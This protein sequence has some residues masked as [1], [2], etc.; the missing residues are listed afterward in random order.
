VAKPRQ[1]GEDTRQL[2]GTAPTDPLHDDASGLL[3]TTGKKLASWGDE[4]GEASEDDLENIAERTLITGAPGMSGF[5]MDVGGDGDGPV[6][7]TLVTTAPP[8]FGGG[9]DSTAAPAPASASDDDDNDDGPTLSRDFSLQPTMPVRPTKARV[10]VRPPAALA[11]KI[12]APA[13]SEL[14]KPRPRRNTPPGGSPVVGGNVLQAIVGSAASAPMPTPRPSP[15]PPPSSAA[16]QSTIAMQSSG[17][18]QAH[19]QPPPP[20]PPPQQ[21]MMP[22]AAPPGPHTPA[23]PYVAPFP[24]GTPGAQPSYNHDASG[25][26]MGIPTPPGVSVAP[27]Q[28]VPYAQAP[29]GYPGYP[30][31]PV[32]AQAQMSP[33]HGYSQVTP[34][35]LYGLQPAPQPASL[36]GQMRL[37]EVDEIPSQYKLGA[38]RQRWFTYIIS[39]ILAVSV[40][41]GVTFLII[42]STRDTAPTAGS[43]RLE[44]VPA[45]ASALFDGTRMTERTPLTVDGVPLGSHHTIRFELDGYQA[46]EETVDIPKDGR[47]VQVQKQLTPAA[48]GKIVI[49][50]KPRG[51]EI[52]INNTRRGLSPTTLTGIDM[53]S[54]K[55]IELKLNPYEPF[56]QNLVWKDG[57]ADVNATLQQPTQ[58]QPPR[59]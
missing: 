29:G 13:L 37:W 17:T 50:S 35:A 18:M 22:A 23:N 1:I 56:R 26:P 27:P 31:Q 52:W 49:D 57:R 11:A 47:Q 4:R 24:A 40:A 41:A 19:A 16:M 15:S 51:A 42:R 8:G 43:V 39:G 58:Q 38:A 14:R 7:A 45:G 30:A 20:P 48:T 9:E 34:G 54:T 2:E 3:T 36:T 5:M 12:H 55:Q 28:A 53:S 10:K 32:A 59:R 6:E 21:P 46:V 33:P 44:S 25:L